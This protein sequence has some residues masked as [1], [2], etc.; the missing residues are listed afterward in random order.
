METHAT[1]KEDS[2]AQAE[3]PASSGST[4]EEPTL[5][6]IKELARNG[7]TKNRASW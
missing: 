7:L 2:T 4:K 6:Y 1:L 5:T 3:A